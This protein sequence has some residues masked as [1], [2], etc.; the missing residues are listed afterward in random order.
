MKRLVLLSLVLIFGVVGLAVAAE[1]ESK[2]E[3]AK[4]GLSIP[5]FGCHNQQVFQDRFPHEMHRG[6]GVHCNQCHIVKAHQSI[7]LNGQ[8]CTNCHK[9]GRMKMAKTSMPAI[10]DH[11]NHM[12][13]LECKECHSGLFP[14]KAGA[15]KVTM[16]RISA[17]KDCGACHNGK[18]ASAATN[19]G[20]CHKSA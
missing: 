10:F 7:T 11:T 8:T 14:M 15:S 6:M 12:S 9:L 3:P 1:H 4:T 5:C 18:K 20:T 16:D 19:C 13:M 2:A 17:G